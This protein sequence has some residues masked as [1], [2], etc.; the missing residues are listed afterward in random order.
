MPIPRVCCQTLTGHV[1]PVHII[2][3]NSGSTYLLSAGADRT[4]RIWNAESGNLVKAYSGGHGKEV[5]G[6][7]V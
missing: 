5:L 7:D 6:L 4:I 3:F 1:G 2:T